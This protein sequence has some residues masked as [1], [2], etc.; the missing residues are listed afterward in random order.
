MPGKLTISHKEYAYNVGYSR[1]GMQLGVE[2]FMSIIS[3]TLMNS[4]MKKMDG[5]CYDAVA[6][7]TYTAENA[8]SVSSAPASG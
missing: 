6:G 5:I 7:L 8:V 2:S 3:T 1:I 4:M